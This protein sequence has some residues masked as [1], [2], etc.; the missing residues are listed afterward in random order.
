MS[1][2]YIKQTKKA[3][4]TILAAF[5]MLLSI[6]IKAGTTP[7]QTTPVG[8]EFYNSSN[9]F[10]D[11]I[12]HIT[13]QQFNGYKGTGEFISFATNKGLLIANYDSNTFTYT[14]LID[15]LNSIATIVP[16]DNSNEIWLANNNGS[17]VKIANIES[18]PEYSVLSSQPTGTYTTCSFYSYENNFIYFGSNS[19][20]GVAAYYTNDSDPSPQ[21]LFNTQN[22]NDIISEGFTNILLAFDDS[23]GY[24]SG[25]SFPSGGMVNKS[26]FAGIKNMCYVQ[27]DSQTLWYSTADSLY[28]YNYDS[29][30]TTHIPEAQKIGSIVDI[31]NYNSDIWIAGKKGLLKYT[32]NPSKST[33]NGFTSELFT[34]ADGLPNADITSIIATNSGKI[35]IGTNGAGIVTISPTEQLNVYAYKTTGLNANVS[36]NL[37][38]YNSDSIVFTTNY[39]DNNTKD[40]I[41][42]YNYSYSEN[43]TYRTPGTYKVCVSAL[44]NDGISASNCTYVT[45]DDGSNNTFA[46]F[47]IEGIIG[48]GVY[49][50]NKSRSTG[51]PKYKWEMGDGTIYTD[52]VNVMGHKYPANGK[53]TITLNLYNTSTGEVT[54]ASK[55][56][57]I[58]GSPNIVTAPFASFGHKI[59]DKRISLINNSTGNI[60]GYH[61]D[62][63]D[64]Y[65]STLKNPSHT[66]AKPGIYNIIL[67]AYD[68]VNNKVSRAAN[69]IEIIDTVPQCKVWCNYIPD[70]KISVTVIPPS[71]SVDLNIVF[72]GKATG[73]TDLYFW[74]FGDGQYASG[75][76]LDTLVHKYTK[77][78]VYEVS[79]TARSSD[80]KNPAFGKYTQK[81]IVSAPDLS[82]YPN[83]PT[84]AQFCNADFSP[85]VYGNKLALINKSKFPKGLIVSYRWDFGD[86]SYSTNINAVHTYSK[87]GVYK[88][89]LTV[90]GPAISELMDTYT[91]TIRIA[92][93]N[94]AVFSADFSYFTDG[95]K[96]YFT[97]DSQGDVTHYSWYFGDRQGH[98]TTKQAVYNFKEPGYYTVVHR[99]YNSETG[100]MDEVSKEIVVKYDESN[101]KADFVFFSHDNINY[102]FMSRSIGEPDS[103]SWDFD[104]G[105]NSNEENPSHKFT[106]PGYYNVSLTVAQYGA[107]D[108][109]L[110]TITKNVYVPANTKSDNNIVMADFVSSA[111]T[112][113]STVT[114]NN[115]S[116]GNVTGLYWDFGDNTT[117]VNTQNP[118]HEYAQSGYYN[119]CLTARS[120]TH[121]NTNCK[122]IAVGDITS[123]HSA[124]FTYFVDATKN[125][126]VF[127]NKSAG[128]IVGY[129]WNF[130]DG[131]TSMEEQPSHTYTKVGYYAVCLT[132]TSASGASKTFCQDININAADIDTCTYNCVWPGDANHDLEA[133]HYDILTI[134]MNYGMEGPARKNA[135]NNWKGQNS[136]PWANY[137]LDSTNNM[138][139]DCNGDGIINLNDTLA[140]RQNFA[141][142]HSPNAEEFTKAGEWTLTAEISEIVPTKGAATTRVVRS[143][144]SEPSD[145]AENEIYGLGYEL[146]LVGVE[147][148]NWNGIV[149][150]FNGSILSQTAN[151]IITF[152]TVDIAKST[153]YISLC[154]NDQQNIS[155]SGAVAT[156]Y[157]P[158]PD[159]GGENIEVIITTD[160]GIEANGTDVPVKG[161][162]FYISSPDK[163]VESTFVTV[164]PNPNN[165]QFNVSV[166][167]N[168]A[169]NINIDVL[170]II[171][172]PVLS[173][174]QNI[175]H[176]LNEIPV[177]S[178]DIAQGIYNVKITV[179]EN[180][181]V[182]RIIVQ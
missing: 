17:I 107:A 115:R 93:D 57:E 156:I 155:Q 136:Q 96:V 45:V 106:E 174:Q 54:S 121:Q 2:N 112:I 5:I 39:G 129:K 144:L 168:S 49:L 86:G 81:V 61:W 164:Y 62:F 122:T 142:S 44:T 162:T 31:I 166:Y 152:Y 100:L 67:Y 27:F 26:A 32:Y 40:T 35:I 143:I 130:G 91:Q 103:Y 34:R 22:I 95:T 149:V 119:V 173:L 138:H 20:N 154:K 76:N 16:K 127:D 133:N 19:N 77:P 66:F 12:T 158:F 59:T 90:S 41:I 98:A 104:N 109:I 56:I 88:V 146:E 7:T 29:K 139:G 72:A 46:D 170:N 79:L 153:I 126:V 160:G 87:P 167:S 125:L 137:Q 9:G 141:F 165:G 120:T 161:G 65:T 15:S 63:C 171:G 24:I 58:Y 175:E 135:S 148:I 178:G 145:K 94:T 33:P 3:I 159:G 52:S 53:Y 8:W 176:G 105:Y 84:L 89:K 78:G 75:I 1:K 51:T 73:G 30:E 38:Y 117:P 179:G 14:T 123:K 110:N 101:I 6:N 21:I 82:S 37:D 108:T 111:S 25:D 23:L 64:G 70:T 71:V 128:N 177:V 48:D 80:P 11:S 83:A 10:Y 28:V 118:V 99:I 47:L 102:K 4:I 150:D 60:T 13:I 180:T 172:Q 163:Q 55:E 36:V 97:D 68:T 134:G 169:Q 140:I 114:F 131:V 151:D 92:P 74:D 85:F 18:T 182:K 113:D 181:I 116:L 132:T 157:L 50:N 147:G 124:L 69:K 43:Y 42:Y